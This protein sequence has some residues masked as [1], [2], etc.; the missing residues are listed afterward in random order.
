MTTR[1]GKDIVYMRI[2]DNDSRQ[3]EHIL[4]DSLMERVVSLT[5]NTCVKDHTIK[6]HIPLGRLE[7]R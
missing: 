3:T 5:N 7:W 6:K 2:K 4:Q 1:D